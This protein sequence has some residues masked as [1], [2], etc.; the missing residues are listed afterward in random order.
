MPE[1]GI[2]NRGYLS[3]EISDVW[4]QYF[5]KTINGQVRADHCRCFTTTINQIN[6]QNKNWTQSRRI[7]KTL[8]ET[9]HFKYAITNFNFYIAF[10]LN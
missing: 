6:K 10:L 2:W 8:H 4:Q 7:K 1:D 9:M 3:T 5:F